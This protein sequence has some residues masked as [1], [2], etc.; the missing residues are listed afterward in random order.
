MTEEEVWRCVCDS[1]H[2]PGSATDEALV[3]LAKQAIET[4]NHT[5]PS[6]LM[7]ALA[8]RDTPRAVSLFGSEA[9]DFV[10]ARTLL[11]SDEETR[12]AHTALLMLQDKSYVLQIAKAL[13]GKIEIEEVYLL[14]KEITDYYRL[15]LWLKN[16]ENF[17]YFSRGARHASLNAWGIAAYLFSLRLPEELA[18]LGDI[19]LKNSDFMTRKLPRVAAEKALLW[20]QENPGQGGEAGDLLVDLIGQALGLREEEEDAALAVLMLDGAQRRGINLRPILA[21]LGERAVRDNPR[22]SRSWTRQILRTVPESLRP[23]ARY[24]RVMALQGRLNHTSLRPKR[25]QRAWRWRRRAGR[26]LGCV[27]DPVLRLG[28]ERTLAHD[29]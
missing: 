1:V 24:L 9:E 18:V 17:R 12:L 23:T 15:H 22:A 13:E 16:S 7:T 20:L 4:E 14:P 3:A 21:M 29:P 19:F 28:L 5:F 10:I 2:S 26:I 8:W 25:Q 27:E 11:S 6:L